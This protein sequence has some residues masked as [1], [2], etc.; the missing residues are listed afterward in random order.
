[1]RRDRGFDL[2]PGWI[3]QFN[4]RRIALNPY[5][6]FLERERMRMVG[7]DPECPWIGRARFDDQE[8]RRIATRLLDFGNRRAGMQRK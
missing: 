2:T 7:L 4:R 6:N 8:S 1:M 5:I 3:R